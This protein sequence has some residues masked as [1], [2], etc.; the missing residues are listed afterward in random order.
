[1]ALTVDVYKGCIKLGTGTCTNGST[2]MTTYSGT[3]P[4]SGRNVQLAV[5]AAVSS[6][7]GS[8]FK[9]KI[10]TDGGATLTLRDACPFT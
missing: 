4:I 1:M 6:P 9:T 10:I 7:V 2:S 5:T 3:A 8:S